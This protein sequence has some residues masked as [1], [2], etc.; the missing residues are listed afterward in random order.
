LVHDWSKFRPSEFLPYARYFYG[1]YPLYSELPAGL[2][3]ILTGRFREDVEREFDHAWLLHQKRNR[4]HWQFWILPTDEEGTKVMPVPMKYVREMLADWTGASKAQGHDGD[5]RR[6]WFENHQ[7][8][9][10]HG[11]AYRWL[12]MWVRA[13]RGDK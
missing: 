6:W 1:D 9:Q 2:K 10:I 8:I 11:E 3:Y 7:K 5:I 13:R 4:H 12:D